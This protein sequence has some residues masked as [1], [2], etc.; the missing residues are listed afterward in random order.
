MPE[1]TGTTKHESLFR[2]SVVRGFASDRRVRSARCA[3]TWRGG[4]SRASISTSRYRQLSCHVS[5]PGP[6]Q[7]PHAQWLPSKPPHTLT[8]MGVVLVRDFH[9]NALSKREHMAQVRKGEIPLPPFA[10]G[11]VWGILRLGP[12][13]V[14]CTSLNA[15]CVSHICVGLSAVFRGLDRTS[16]A[17]PLS[18]QY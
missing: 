9:R 3:W 2:G 7:S 10:K 17:F 14:H 8:R 6:A 15:T 12:S 16:S 1:I 5:C 4:P 11:R 18:R 13:P